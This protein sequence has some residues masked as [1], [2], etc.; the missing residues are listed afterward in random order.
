MDLA[1]QLCSYALWFP[2]EALAI[3]SVLRLGIRRYPL[4]F[5]YLVVSF[6]A[7]CASLP[8]V[9]S[10]Y[11]GRR[12]NGTGYVHLYWLNEGITD[13][14]ILAVV[15]TLIYRASGHLTT[16]RTVRRGLALGS[17]LYIGVSFLIHYQHTAAI[18]LWMAPWT[19]DITF[20][21]AILDL[22]LWAILIGSRS[23]DSRLLM[24]SGG[25]GIMFCGLAIG[26]SLR[27]IAIHYRSHPIVLAGNALEQIGN[28]IF[29]YVWWQTF[30][31]EASERVAAPLA[32]K[33]AVLHE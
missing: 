21:A 26:E 15:V 31:R 24:L 4:I 9:W 14:L 18:G 33:T 20:C 11:E 22:A 7:A 8:A 5:A 27:T 25:M 29:L 16:R 23:K 2:L 6:L 30:R 13:A 12:A 3:S 10:Y 1:F 28:I 17:V 32:P 19:R